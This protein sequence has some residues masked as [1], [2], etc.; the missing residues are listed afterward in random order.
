[1]LAHHG[2]HR[3]NFGRLEGPRSPKYLSAGQAQLL[4]R[5]RSAPTRK[6]LQSHKLRIITSPA[7]PAYRP[8]TNSIDFTTTGSGSKK[9]KSV[10]LKQEQPPSPAMSGYS[11][12]SSGQGNYS[13]QPPY[14]PGI[15]Q[16][17]QHQIHAYYAQ[18]QCYPPEPWQM[19][20]E[21]Y[22]EQQPMSIPHTAYQEPVTGYESTGW[23]LQDTD[24]NVSASP[25]QKRTWTCDIPTC[26]SSAQFTRLADLQRHQSTVH[27]VGTPEYPCHVARCNRVGEKGFTRRDHLVEHL[28]NFHHIDIP[29]RKPGERSAFPFGWPE[30]GVG[31]AAGV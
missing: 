26:T 29:R 10:R 27:G 16:Y 8:S 9:T 22:V 20:Q 13:Y 31:G 11:Y 6:T 2:S 25:G 19:V 4:P 15:P 1:M 14:Q 24:V 21:Y 12:S 30:G 17:T 18:Y 28:R 7:A 5:K 23:Q 3:D